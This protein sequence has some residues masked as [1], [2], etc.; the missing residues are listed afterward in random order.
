M[1]SSCHVFYTV[2]RHTKLYKR[3]IQL[4]SQIHLRHL[5]SILGIKWSDRLTNNEVLQRADMPSIETMLL[6]R[7]L[8]WTGHVVRMNDDRLPKAVLYGELWQAKRNVEGHTYVTTTRGTGRRWRAI[9]V[10]GV[11]P[12]KKKPQKPK[13]KSNRCRNQTTTPP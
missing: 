7:Q 10:H 13:P 1:L 11:R 6:S 2:Q 4:L 5:R 12:S 9:A 8:T 3:H